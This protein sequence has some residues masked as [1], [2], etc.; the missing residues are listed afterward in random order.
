MAIK[1]NY[2]AT[3]AS[4][5]IRNLPEEVLERIRALSAVERRSLNSEIL[6][7][8]ERGTSREYDDRLQRPRLLTRSAQME[9]WK[10]LLGSWVD[11]RTTREIVDDIRAAR[12]RGRD[13]QL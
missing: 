10:G 8:L 5:T 11:T 1:Q 2:Y 13:V 4:I 6:V 9:A 3:M 12:T 7:I